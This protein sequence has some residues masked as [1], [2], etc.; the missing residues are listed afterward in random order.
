MQFSFL[1]CKE[2]PAGGWDA[3]WRGFHALYLGRGGTVPVEEEREGALEW[4]GD[5]AAAV[6]F[7][8]AVGRFAPAAKAY[9]LLL[10][11]FFPTVCGFC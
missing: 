3:V 7:A 8:A 9:D 6:I 5:V 10:L 11:L 4:G 2:V 1:C